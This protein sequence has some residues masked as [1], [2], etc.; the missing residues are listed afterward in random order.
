MSLDTWQRQKHAFGLLKKVYAKRAK[1]R[2]EQHSFNRRDAGEV[3]SRFASAF[4][5]ALTGKFCLR[6]PSLENTFCTP[7]LVTFF[8]SVRWVVV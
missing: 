3:S 6:R 5:D 2:G 7:S 8:S 1:L 4:A